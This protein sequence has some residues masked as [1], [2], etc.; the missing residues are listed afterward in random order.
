MP[1]ARQPARRKKLKENDV[2]TYLKYTND[3]I[4]EQLTYAETKHA[5]LIGFVGAT[6]FAIVGVIFE[7][8][9]CNLTWLKICLGVIAGFLLVPLF[10]SFSSFF[11]NT[12]G[13]KKDKRNI[14]FYGDIAK[15][16][17]T[18][19][20]LSEIANCQDPEK[21][22]A[23]QNIQVSAIIMKKHKKFKLSLYCCIASII[24]VFYIYIFI[25]LFLLKR[26]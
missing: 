17:D 5:V 25:A 12:N 1:S 8:K 20:Y 7:I 26:I 10:I 6:I 23:A 15:Y 11:P 22:L 21:H 9:G 16:N 24:P 18:E 4:Y 19:T 13:L 14:Y 3:R 2:E